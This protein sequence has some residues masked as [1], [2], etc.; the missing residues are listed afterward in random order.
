[1]RSLAVYSIK[2]GVGKTTI[3]MNLAWCAAVASQRRTLVWDL[4]PHGGSTFLL[5]AEPDQRRRA[6]SVFAREVDPQ[7]LICRTSHERLDLLPADK[8]LGNLD[9][10]LTTLDRRKRLSKIAASLAPHYD[11][12]I[13]D[14]PPVM[15][16]VSSQVFRAADAILV[17][18]SPSPLAWRALDD[19][20]QDLA[21]NHKGHGPI[22]PVLS[23]VDRR[24]TLHRAACDAHPDWHVIPMSSQAEQVAVRREAL[25]SFNPNSPVS[26]AFLALWRSVEGR[27]V[28][29]P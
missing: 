29:T 5:R 19:V 22:L 4:D 20:R 6:Q 16:E 3:A 13:F 26:R 18:L 8:S 23:M 14:C 7:A 1:M 15:N 21:R 9:S 12:I 28:A 25:C 11:R 2:G 17:P 10:F 24:R 27:L